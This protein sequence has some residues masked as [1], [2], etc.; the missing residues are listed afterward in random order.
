MERVKAAK[1]GSGCTFQGSLARAADFG[2]ARAAIE[3]GLYRRAE[4]FGA[5][6]VL[7]L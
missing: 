6:G 1:Q 7:P 2:G 4:A 5:E 3:L